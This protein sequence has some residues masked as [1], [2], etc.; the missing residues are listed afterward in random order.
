M[1]WRSCANRLRRASYQYNLAIILGCN[2]CLSC[3]AQK[4]HTILAEYQNFAETY[5]G[6]TRLSK[7]IYQ[8]TRISYTLGDSILAGFAPQRLTEQAETSPS[9]ALMD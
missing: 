1:C 4:E 6:V 7:G 8:P 5:R 9:A 3:I 2:S